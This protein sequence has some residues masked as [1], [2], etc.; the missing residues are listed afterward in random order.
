MDSSVPEATLRGRRQFVDAEYTSTDEVV[1]DMNQYDPVTQLL[2]ENHV[3]VTN[4]GVRLGP[5][6]CRSPMPASW[7]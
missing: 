2:D 7:T 3:H 1:L 4:D 6:S 5:I